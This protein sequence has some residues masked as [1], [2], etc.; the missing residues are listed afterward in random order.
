[1]LVNVAVVV[2]LQVK[3]STT[4]DEAWKEWEAIILALGV[5]AEGCIIGLLLHLSRVPFPLLES[6]PWFQNLLF[7][8]A[9]LLSNHVSTCAWC[10]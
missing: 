1:M 6:I 7:S 4:I 5:V 3:L 9:H 2:V 10:C 8:A